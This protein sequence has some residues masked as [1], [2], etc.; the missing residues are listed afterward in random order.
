MLK[1][2]SMKINFVLIG[3]VIGLFIGVSIKQAV[4]ETTGVAATCENAVCVPAGASAQWRAGNLIL[5]T[6][7]QF[8]NGLLVPYG[9]V[10]IGT[11][12]PTAKLDVVG[13]VKSSQGFCINDVCVTKWDDLK[14]MLGVGGGTPDPFASIKTFVS[15]GVA[16]PWQNDPVCN[17]NKVYVRVTG[18]NRSNPPKGCATPAAHSADCLDLSKHR[19][20]TAAEWIDDTTIQTVVNGPDYPIGNYDFYLSYGTSAKKVGSGSLKSCAAKYEWACGFVIGPSAPIL[21]GYT[22]NA[23][24]VGQTINV[25]TTNNARVDCT[26][27]A[28]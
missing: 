16:G 12:T 27:T 11:L 23:S 26:C 13:K 14:T 24:N 17:T 3:A 5:N 22:C 2:Y 7:N 8:A 21:T 1:K 6:S 15:T 18:V 19:S 9:N 10:G 20:Y 4:G 28:K 25:P